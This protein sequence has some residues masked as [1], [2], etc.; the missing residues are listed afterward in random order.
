LRE[1]EF[2]RVDKRGFEVT[3]GERSR[4][5]VS[6][7]LGANMNRR[8]IANSVDV[9]VMVDVRAERGNK[10]SGVGF[11]IGDTGKKAEEVSF[12]VLFLWDPMFFSTVVNDCVLMGVSVNSEGTGGGVEE[13]R[14]EVF[15]RYLWE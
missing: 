8:K 15:Y 4:M 12:Y 9:N 7:N 3:E 2:D 14:E 10:G 13:V 11:K 5:G 1:D 6:T